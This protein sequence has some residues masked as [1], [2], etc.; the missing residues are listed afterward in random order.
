MLFHITLKMH[1]KCIIIIFSAI[2][3]LYH[4]DKLGNF[5]QK[6]NILSFFSTFK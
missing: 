1:G 2:K 4:T 6:L 3:M 5:L